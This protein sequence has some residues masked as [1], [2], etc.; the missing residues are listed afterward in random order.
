MIWQDLSPLILRSQAHPEKLQE[1]LLP[2]IAYWFKKTSP[3]Y[4]PLLT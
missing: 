4:Y 2:I 1:L 3:D